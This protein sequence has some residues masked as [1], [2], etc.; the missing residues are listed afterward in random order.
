[1]TT[2]A[3]SLKG[4]KAVVTGGTDGIGLAVAKRFAQFGA[5]VIIASRRKEGSEIATRAGLSFIRCDVSDESQVKSLFQAVKEEFGKLDILVNNAGAASNEGFVSPGPIST[6]YWPEDAPHT[7]Q[8]TDLIPLGRVGKPA[9]V[10]CL[11]HYLAAD[12]SRF[13]TGQDIAIDG[14]WTAGLSQAVMGKVFS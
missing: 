8:V 13:I 9:E 3:F 4:K 14:G 11:F 5:E 1:M 2:N 12:E 10:A 7:K 6:R